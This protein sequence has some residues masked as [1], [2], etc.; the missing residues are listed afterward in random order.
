[1]QRAGYLVL[2]YVFD[3]TIFAVDKLAIRQSGDVPWLFVPAVQ[4]K[5]T[6]TRER[7]IDGLSALCREF[8]LRSLSRDLEI[9]KNTPTY[10]IEHGFNALKM[11]LQSLWPRV[12]SLETSQQSTSPALTRLQES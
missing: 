10:R 3:R 7:N 9:F 5:A 2:L 6:L 12:T 4:W 11:K 8:Q 1:L